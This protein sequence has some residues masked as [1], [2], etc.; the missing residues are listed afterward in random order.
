VPYRHFLQHRQKVQFLGGLDVLVP[1]LDDVHAAGK[2][3]VHELRKVAAV[4]P[5][6]G[7]EIQAGSLEGLAVPGVDNLGIGNSAGRSVGT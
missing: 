3:R 7:A 2:G 1:Q 4:P 5:R 6:I